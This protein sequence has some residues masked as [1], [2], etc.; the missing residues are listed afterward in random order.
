MVEIN[1]KHVIDQHPK[2]VAEAFFYPNG[3]TP[4]HIWLLSCVDWSANVTEEVP[5]ST[6]TVPNWPK[7][8]D[9]IPKSP[10]QPSC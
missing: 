4:L 9:A 1:R 2:V 5:V 10:S 3:D 8:I 7:S 6:G